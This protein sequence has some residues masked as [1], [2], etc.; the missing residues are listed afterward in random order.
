[1]KGKPNR[2]R[3]G[4]CETYK[5]WKD[6]ETI[7]NNYAQKQEKKTNASIPIFRLKEIKYSAERI[8]R[9]T[10]QPLSPKRKLNVFLRVAQLMDRGFVER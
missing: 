9:G 6:I 5:E 3:T 1:M 4:Y 7:S 10:T 2:K 8:Q